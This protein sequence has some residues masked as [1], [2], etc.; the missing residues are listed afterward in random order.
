M[1]FESNG[2][3]LVFRQLREV[4]VFATTKYFATDYRYTWRP[5]M[6]ENEGISRE[7]EGGSR[8]KRDKFRAR[9]SK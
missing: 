5:I 3:T 4:A 6:D 9:G 2:T 8:S 7:K 1:K